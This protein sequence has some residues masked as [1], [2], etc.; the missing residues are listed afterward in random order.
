MNWKGAARPGTQPPG[1]RL[2]SGR[3]RG[4]MGSQARLSERRGT[5]DV[6]RWEAPR[7]PVRTSDASL[8]SRY[9]RK[10]S[11]QAASSFLRSQ[12]K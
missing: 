1:P 11:H 10:L 4:E 5:P 6:Q 7:P 9:G 2:G 12:W 8:V 3:S